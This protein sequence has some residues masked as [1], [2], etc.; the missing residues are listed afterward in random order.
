MGKG[1]DNLVNILDE[2][3]KKFPQKTAL[4]FGAK[5]TGEIGGGAG[6]DVPLGHACPRA[7]W[8]DGSRVARR[9]RA[10]RRGLR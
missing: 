9:P 3:S 1:N 4:V 10:A 2:S 5:D 6:L 7:R 8:A